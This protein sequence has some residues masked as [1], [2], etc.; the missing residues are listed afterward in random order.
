MKQMILA[1]ALSL[2]MLAS[3]AGGNLRYT[4]IPLAGAKQLAAQ[5]TSAV[6]HPDTAKVFS[7]VLGQ[8]VA[9]NRATVSLQRGDTLLVGQYTGPRLPEGATTLPEG[10]KITWV[11]VDVE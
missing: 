1:N 5:C 7:S 10:A 3:L 6:G 4:E 2:N 11:R 9:C 8:E